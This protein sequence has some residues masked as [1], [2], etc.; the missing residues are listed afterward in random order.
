[1]SASSAGE[2]AFASEFGSSRSP[3]WYAL[4]GESAEAGR[5]R[6][7]VDREDPVEEEI[8]LALLRLDVDV[9]GCWSLMVEACTVA[10]QLYK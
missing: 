4:V 2:S 6:Y 10:E 3:S 5:I 1:M 8:G 7:G 9:V